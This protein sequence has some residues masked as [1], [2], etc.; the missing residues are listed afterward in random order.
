MKKIQL[1]EFA[2]VVLLV[3]SFFIVSLSLFLFPLVASS[4]FIYTH[5]FKKI[6]G[7]PI[8]MVMVEPL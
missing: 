7:E 5:F 8:N 1:I 3:A 4:L 6:R 2:I